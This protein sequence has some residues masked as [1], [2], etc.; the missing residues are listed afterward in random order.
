MFLCSIMLKHKDINLNKYLLI[1]DVPT[2]ITLS[3]QN[4]DNQSFLSKEVDSFVDEI[5][6]AAFQEMK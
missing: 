5:D 1:S 4:Y 2:R 6:F 3:R